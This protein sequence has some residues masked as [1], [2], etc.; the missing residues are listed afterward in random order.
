M[1]DIHLIRIDGLVILA[2]ILGSIGG[3]FFKWHV[4]IAIVPII[5][6]W[7]FNYDETSYEHKTGNNKC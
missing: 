5:M 7:L 6:I 3:I 1:K 2:L 4:L